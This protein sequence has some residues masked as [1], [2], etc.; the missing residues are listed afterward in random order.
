M[1]SVTTPLHFELDWYPAYSYPE[2]PASF[3]ADSIPEHW[4]KLTTPV[5][6][7]ERGI[8][9]F[10]DIRITRVTADGAEVGFHVNAFPEKPI[11]RVHFEQVEL[12]AE[13]PGFIR[14]ARDWTMDEVTLSVQVEERLELT[15]CEG[16][17]EPR[18]VYLDK[19][20]PGEV[21]GTGAAGPD[22]VPAA[23]GA[24]G[25]ITVLEGRSK[26][27]AQGDTISDDPLS[28]YVSPG[29][30]AGFTLAEP[31][32]DGF[33]YSPLEIRWDQTDRVLLVSGEVSHQWTIYI[34]TEEEP[35]D[36]AG[37][38]TWEYLTDEAMLVVRKRGSNFSI[39]H[40]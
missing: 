35:E 3:P 34:R 6:P 38:D 25:P 28:M 14:H 11:S 8:P 22:P 21:S 7:T 18:Y 39:N 19:G 33:Y 23:M 31:L 37:G 12:E 15:D 32:G 17:E 2:I 20:E 24:S 16:V 36:V 9:Q 29:R 10:Q 13:N 1:E 40:N 30:P 27:L 5:V 4:T 26:R